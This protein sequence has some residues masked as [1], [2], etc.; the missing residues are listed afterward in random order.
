MK[1]K[2]GQSPV[3]V[4][5][6]VTVKG[7]QVPLSA[8]R[9]FCKVAKVQALVG[10]SEQIVVG[11]SDADVATHLGVEL[12]PLQSLTLHGVDLSTWYLDGKAGEGVSITYQK[13]LII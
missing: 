3:S 8:T 4:K 2:K 13:A 6:T 12:V 7:T 9:I 11:G 5:K 1:Y 10:N